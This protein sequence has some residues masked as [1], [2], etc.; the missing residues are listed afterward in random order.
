MFPR[1]IINM[2]IFSKFNTRH[3][4][5]SFIG[6]ACLSDPYIVSPSIEYG[7]KFDR[8][9]PCHKDLIYKW[10]YIVYTKIYS[11][12]RNQCD[13]YYQEKLA[14]GSPLSRNLRGQDSMMCSGVCNGAP[15]SRIQVTS[16]FHA[17]L[18]PI[19]HAFWCYPPVVQ[20]ENLAPTA[21]A[22]C[23]FA[24]SLTPSTNVTQAR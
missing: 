2:Y 17:C 18:Q 4:W 16:Q 19:S 21:A 6:K 9:R 22:P 20:R 13:S 5:Q 3:T 23:P 14:Y 8:W 12:P 10:R 24:T 11:R 1:G 7:S 15:Q